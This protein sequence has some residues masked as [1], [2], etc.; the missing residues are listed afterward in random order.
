MGDGTVYGEESGIVWPSNRFDSVTLTRLGLG[1]GLAV[2][3]LQIAN[4]YAAL[5]NG[6]KTVAPHLVSKTVSTNGVE[7]IHDSKRP[8]LQIVSD[9]TS[10]TIT[11]MMKDAMIA[12]GK[13]FAVDLKDLDVAG[14]ISE[15]RL[16]VDGAYS[17][18]D[19]NV[20]A[21]GFFPTESPRWV[22]VIGFTKPHPVHSAGMVA[23]PVFSDI[24]LEIMISK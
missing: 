1:R 3:G 21:A 10:K 18:T 22:L 2:T 7:T 17:E 13:E 19:Y 11:S 23:L 6:G 5:A 16:P 15:T 4:A 8:P 9:K 24:A 12:A 14:A 20:T